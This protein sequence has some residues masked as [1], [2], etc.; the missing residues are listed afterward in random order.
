[1]SAKMT[2]NDVDFRGKRV[3][4]RVD[5]N[6][7]LDDNGN[8]TDDTRVVKALPT[9]VSV[10]PWLPRAYVAYLDDPSPSHLGAKSVGARVETSSIL[11]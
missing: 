1:M 6:V 7:P 11:P 9:I 4:C 2:L 3:L 10:V 8:I 5:F